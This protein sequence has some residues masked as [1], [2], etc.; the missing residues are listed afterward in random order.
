MRSA[1]ARADPGTQ[2]RAGEMDDKEGFYRGLRGQAQQGE[3]TTW[4]MFWRRD[5]G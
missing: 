3:G 5:Y 4:E 2:E 1:G